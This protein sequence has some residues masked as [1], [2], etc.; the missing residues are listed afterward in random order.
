MAWMLGKVWTNPTC[1]IP[2]VAGPLGETLHMFRLTGTLYC[3]AELSAPWGIDVPTLPG[4][5]TLQV[6]TAGRCWLEVDGTE[7][8][9]IGPGSLTLIPDGIAHRFRSAP[10]ASTEPL[11]DI[12]VQR[13]SDRYEIMRHG[14]GGEL[15]QV[16]YAVLRPDHIAARR[17]VAQLPPVLHLDRFDDDETGWLHSTLRLVTR[18]AQT[19]QPGGE[20]MLTRLADVLVIQVIRAWLD[21]APEARQGW[22]AALRDE[23]IGQALTA[24]HRAPEHDWSVAELARHAGMSRSAFA[25]RFTELVG[26]PVIRYLANWRLQLAHDHL[27]QSAEPLPVV[28]RRFGYQSEAAFCRAFKRVYGMPPGQLRRSGAS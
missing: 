27:R 21:T 14:G 11:F 3:R 6:V 18:E 1:A 24:L 17:L 25:A 26:E 22:L 28:A 10:D 12:P 2:A 15:T 8:Q 19:L 13:L 5:M 23:Q 16:T 4:C 20:T 7:P 9:L